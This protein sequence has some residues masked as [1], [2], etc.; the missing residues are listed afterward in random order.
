MKNQ[1]ISPI[2]TTFH[3]K[4]WS[5]KRY[6]IFNSL[7]K[8]IKI[9]A[10]IVS[11]C[12]ISNNN[13]L[14][15]QTDID[16]ATKVIELEEV[17]IVA[18]LLDQGL[19]K[20]GRSVTVITQAD[21]RQSPATSIE[22]VIRFAPCVETQSRNLFGI[23]SDFSIRGSTFNQILVL[24]DGMRLNDPLTGHFSG[25]IP[26]PLSQV[27][28]I[29]IL[30]GPAASI[31]GPD[32]VGGVINI[33]TKSFSSKSRIPEPET[34]A[35]ILMGQYNSISANGNVHLQYDD[36]GLDFGM[37]LNTSDGEELPSGISNYFD[38]K[39]ITASLD[40]LMDKKWSA[41]FR[42]AYEI[43]DFNAK[44]FYT[45]NASDTATEVISRLWNQLQ[46]KRVSDM[47]STTLL[48]GY[49][50]TGDT[51]EYFPG[52]ISNVNTTHYYNSFL[53]HSHEINKNIRITFGGQ[54]DY[55]SI[56]SIDR[57]N[58]DDMHTGIFANSVFKSIDRFTIITGIR[59]DYDENFGFE[60][61]PQLSMAYDLGKGNLR[62]SIGR[63]IR[64]ADY[65][66]R[67][68]NT[69]PVFV[70][71][72][73]NIGYP[74]LK[75]ERS[76]SNEVGMDLRPVSSIK[77]SSTAFYRHSKDLIDYVITPASLISDN[78]NL[79]SGGV[80][81]YAQNIAELTTTGIE[82]EASF[83]KT[84]RQNHTIKV[85][86][87]YVYAYSFNND[88]VIAKYISSH[89]RHLVTRRISYTN[90]KRGIQLSL[91]TVFK[92]RESDFIEAINVKH[93]KT[94]MVW[95]AGLNI[96]IYKDFLIGH[97][98]IKNLFNETYYEVLGAKMPG[99]WIMAGIKLK[100]SPIY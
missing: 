56:T 87:G 41:A 70:S 27:E 60:L 24:I 67:Y 3:F 100:V 48:L 62:Y 63:S 5:N 32:A 30:R 77:L 57:G 2:K 58:H 42:I 15:A 75:P 39:K 52:L 16:T 65:T 84:I 40:Y 80:Y 18:T 1:N 98:Q 46:V 45:S 44:N 93:A 38:S 76:W 59:G 66:E 79:D 89:A 90:H 95:D 82:A 78:Q 49:S 85:N 55:R 97:V 33:I 92:E 31:Y 64:A 28:R 6:A 20:A 35:S 54:L 43:D 94:M 21:I 37:L 91:N 53:S 81:Y 10:L 99:R 69:Y 17:D 26:V 22:E 51:F 83:I 88:T 8:Q 68:S 73:R 96:R 4:Q 61:I 86:V 7:H 11:Y 72:G 74:Q 14:I 36:L 29:E 25:N 9:C 13:D 23:Q 71:S 19:D 34:S 12:L 50:Q 47:S